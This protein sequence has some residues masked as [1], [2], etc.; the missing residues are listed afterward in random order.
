MATHM[1]LDADARR[2]FLARL[3]AENED[4][5]GRPDGRN[6]LRVV[7]DAFEEDWVYLP[8]IV[9]NALDAQASR[10]A[11]N[12]GDD[13]MV[14]EHDRAEPLEDRHVQALSK[15]WWSTKGLDS[16]GFMGLG[17][18]SV[19]SRFRRAAIAGWGLAIRF[20]VE[21][22]VGEC[23]GDR[24]PDLLGIVLPHWDD[25]LAIPEPSFTTRFDLSC[26]IA[27]GTSLGRDVAH[28]VPE[29]EPTVLTILA[30]RVYESFDS[31][32]S[33]GISTQCER[34][35][36]TALSRGQATVVGSPGRCSSRRTGHPTGR[37]HACWSG[38]ECRVRSMRKRPAGNA[39]SWLSCRL[40]MSGI[41][42]RPKPRWSSPRYPRRSRYRFVY[43]CRQTG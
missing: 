39:R 43:I 31:T 35:T 32:A 22:K 42:L 7:T 15:L 6:M 17:F 30:M 19:F 40:T 24:Q 21:V 25:D 8:E 13:Y 4:F 3:R 36:P 27:E 9:Q 28:L 41:L 37:S 33:P 38:A 2:A 10:I 12:W 29:D 34:T 16:I 18:K 5:Y 11:I 26:R 23:F 1:K 20:D 14:I